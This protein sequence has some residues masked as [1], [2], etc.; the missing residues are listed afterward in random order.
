MR[1]GQVYQQAVVVT[2]ADGLHLRPLSQ[3]A[4]LAQQFASDVKIRKE[5]RTVDAKSMLDLMTLNATRG[6]TLHVEAS[7]P[8]AAEAVR[9]LVELFE[10]DFQS[11]EPPGSAPEELSEREN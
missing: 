9:R 5:D 2:A 1:E 8:D 7:G 4:R 11:D 3:I 10:S 6:T